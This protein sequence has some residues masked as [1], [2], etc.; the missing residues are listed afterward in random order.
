M[1]LAVHTAVY[2]APKVTVKHN[3]NAKN[4]AEIQIMNQTVESF[5]HSLLIKER[6]AGEFLRFFS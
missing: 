1:V 5:A 6:S 3:R 4:L 2:A